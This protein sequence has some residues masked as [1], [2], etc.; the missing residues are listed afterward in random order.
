MTAF[1]SL[2][3]VSR[4]FLTLFVLSALL[5]HSPLAS[6]MGE[7]PRAFVSAVLFVWAP[8]FVPSMLLRNRLGLYFV[9]AIPVAAS[10]SVSQATLLLL[11]FNL[12]PVPIVWARWALLATTLC[13]FTWWELLWWRVRRGQ[14]MEFGM[15][16]KEPADKVSILALSVLVAGICVLLLR[17]GAPMHWDADSAAHLSAIRGVIEEDRLFPVAQPYGP[18]GPQGFDPRFGV[19]H[20]LCALIAVTANAGLHHLWG[21]LPGLFAPILVAAFFFAARSITGSNRAALIGALLFSLCY[22]GMRGDWLQDSG[23]PNRVSMLV[24]LVSLGMMFRYL[25][26]QPRWLLGLLGVLL[27]TVSAIHVYHVLEFMFVMTCFFALKLLVVREG[28]AKALRQWAYTAGIALASTLPMVSFR[29]LNAYART[30]EYAGVAQGTLILGNGLYVMNPLRVYAWL[31]PV[32]VV[33]ILLLPYFLWRARRHDSFGFAGAATIGPLALVFNPVLLPLATRVLTLLGHRLLAAVPY[34]LTAAIFLANLPVSAA[35]RWP[36]MRLLHSLGVVL[37]ALAVVITLTHKLAFYRHA[38]T[39]PDRTFPHDIS[40]V[41][42]A[43][44][45]LDSL[46]DGRRVFLSDPATA[47]V[48]PAFSRHYVTAIPFAH[49][50]PIDPVLVSR[51]R[52]AMDVLNPRVSLEKAVSILRKYNVE[53][54][55]VNT[56]FRERLL[57]W[58]YEID[59]GFQTRALEKISSA[60]TVFRPLLSEGGLHVFRVALPETAPSPPEPAMAEGPASSGGTGTEMANSSGRV[61]LLEARALGKTVRTADSIQI[62]FLW[63]CNL[64]LPSED[65]YRLF[66]RMETTF[67]KG[68][69]F[70]PS[71]GKIYRKVLEKKLGVRFRFTVAVDPEDFACPLHLWEKGQVVAETVLVRIPADVA[72]GTYRVSVSLKHL[73]PIPNF[74]PRDYLRDDDY[75]SGI[76][77]GRVEVAKAGAL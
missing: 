50:S 45:R 68:P 44:G 20:A 35:G 71:L 41:A 3:L 38:V 19:F 1:P 8:G 66:V 25:A 39:H 64:P 60:T 21:I 23:Y 37:L 53:Y 43:V 75:Y 9:E 74:T 72:A 15:E 18:G 51:V 2:M 42:D 48:I 52:D 55:V 29:M 67:P 77:I 70:T 6:G 30:N 40:A 33:T 65:V 13:W 73:V 7:G 62:H 63:R 46:V 34:P 31:G 49:A 17:I 14:R 4:A 22:G 16:V 32:G 26:G 12:L 47:Y 69:L 76:E 56:S 59:P 36:R 54:L 61:S 10:L 24:Y 28:K 27:A 58:E 57:G 11:V 5:L